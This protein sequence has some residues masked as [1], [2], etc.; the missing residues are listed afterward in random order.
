MGGHF[1][2]FHAGE[3]RRSEPFPFLLAV[4]GMAQFKL[5]SSKFG[6]LKVSRALCV[7]AC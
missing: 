6:S 3:A 5:L 1:E 2:D 7:D 4:G